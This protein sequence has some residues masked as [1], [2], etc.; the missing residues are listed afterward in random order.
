MPFGVG[1]TGRPDG[2]FI[3]RLWMETFRERQV[4]SSDDCCG[5]CLMPEGVVVQTNIRLLPVPLL[6]VTV[7]GKMH[8]ATILRGQS[9]VCDSGPLKPVPKALAE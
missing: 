6:E 9:S 7:A 8:L 2:E 1:T 4:H 3:S 5:V